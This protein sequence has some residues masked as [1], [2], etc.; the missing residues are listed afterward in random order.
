MYDDRLDVVLAQLVDRRTDIYSHTPFRQRISVTPASHGGDR[1]ISTCYDN[2]EWL[3]FASD[4]PSVMILID[5]V[6]TSGTHFNP[7]FPDEL[8]RFGMQFAPHPS[9]QGI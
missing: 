5:D 9:R 2:L 8:P 6:I 7:H 3:G 4:P 1:H